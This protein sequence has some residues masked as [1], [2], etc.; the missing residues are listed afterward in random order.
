MTTSRQA[1]GVGRASEQVRRRLAEDLL[2]LCDDT[3]VTQRAL[4]RASGVSQAY[5]ARIL[6]CRAAPSVETYV[7]LA[8]PLGADLS[9]RLYPNTGPTIR[10]RHQARILE[11]LLAALSPRWHAFAEVAVRHPGRGWIDAAL[12]AA[13][14]QVVVATEIQSELRRLEQLI[15]WSAEKAASLPSWEGWPHLDGDPTV[16]RLL[17]VRRT[18]SN[19]ETARAFERQLLV[20]Y[21]AHPDDAL[22]ALTG[23]RPWPGPAM[24]WAQVDSAGVRLLARR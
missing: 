13:R 18:R 23:D 6:A 21:P 16:S 12:H 3:G 4:A 14:E 19:V 2:R 10:D 11:G 8:L 5:I 20:A 7:R 15:R 22:A 24:L 1:H 17:V 9:A